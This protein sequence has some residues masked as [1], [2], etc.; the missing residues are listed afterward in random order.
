MRGYR[1]YGKVSCN[2]R[3]TCKS[4]NSEKDFRALNIKVFRHERVV[5]S[6]NIPGHPVCQLQMVEK[7]NAGV[8]P[9]KST[10]P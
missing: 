2:R 9:S 5:V 6:E 1:E 7:L 4:E 10:M 8:V 3:I